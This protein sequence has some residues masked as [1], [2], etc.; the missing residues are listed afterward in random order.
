MRRLSIKLRVTIWY[1]LLVAL[2]AG[3]ALCTLFFSGQAMVR[4]YY[5]EALAG[6]ARPGDRRHP[7]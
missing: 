1:T 6:T 3:L 4:S 5:E 7:L 2:I